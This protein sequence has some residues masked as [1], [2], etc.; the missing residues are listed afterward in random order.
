MKH[1]L[2]LLIALLLILQSGVAHAAPPSLT[3]STVQHGAT[4]QLL[5]GTFDAPPT[6]LQITLPSSWSGAPAT[7]VLS[8]T[9][10]LT[11]DLVRGV[12]APQL[13]TV[14][15]AGGGMQGH[16]YLAGAT[17]ESAPPRRAGRVLLAMVRR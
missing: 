1:R 13:G 16:A 17:I 5:I 8:G 3:V 4:A 15:V 6:E 2:A 10:L 7:V 9:A 14:R 12:G 11:F